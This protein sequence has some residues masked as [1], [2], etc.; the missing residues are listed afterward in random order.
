M[1][2]RKNSSSKV[3]HSQLATAVLNILEPVIAVLDKDHAPEMGHEPP[4][5][6]DRG[7]QILISNLCR[8]CYQQIYGAPKTDNYQGFPGI[9]DAFDRAEAALARHV[10]AYR[11]NPEGMESDPNT[12]KLLR[13][14]ETT[15]ARLSALRDMLTSFQDAYMQMFGVEWK[16]QAPGTVKA[17][18]SPAEA[19]TA[20]KA[21]LA[22]KANGSSVTVD[23][24]AAQQ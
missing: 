6:Q 10:D 7:L 13:F 12:V 2:P 23:T 5:R 3:V 21:I 8:D 24:A 16:Y 20:L 18:T 1:A 17:K 4:S 22:K 11:G 9:K 15:E 14:Y 19:V